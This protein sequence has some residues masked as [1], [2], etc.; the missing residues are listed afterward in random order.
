MTLLLSVWANTYCLTNSEGPQS[1][2]IASQ[3]VGIVRREPLPL[4][5]LSGIFLLRI[6]NETDR[7][8]HVSLGVQ[9]CSAAPIGK[10]APT[11]E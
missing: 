7:F 1:G 2:V 9:R 4:L 3:A 5:R 6:D 10:F 8:R 11:H